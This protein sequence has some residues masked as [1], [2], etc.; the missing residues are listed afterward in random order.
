MRISGYPGCESCGPTA[1]APARSQAPASQNAASLRSAS[2]YRLTA[3]SQSTTSE[4]SL[5]TA[6][7]DRVVLSFST[8]STNAGA[9][10]GTDY[11]SLRSQRSEVKIQVEGDLNPSELRDIQKLAKIVSRAANNAL[12]GD[13]DRAARGLERANKLDSI[14][15]FAFSLNRQVDF[16][17]DYQQQAAAPPA[18]PAP[19]APPAPVESVPPAPAP[20]ARPAPAPAVPVPVEPAPWSAPEL[21]AFAA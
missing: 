14:K 21:Q 19:S 4:L 17:F 6:E 5:T 16:R 9:R 20:S 1:P 7:G 12:R 8:G 15:S 13:G 3:A 18:A 11:A 10:D 2:A